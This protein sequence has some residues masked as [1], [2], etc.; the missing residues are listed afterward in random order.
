MS[1]IDNIKNAFKEVE[2]KVEHALDP[3]EEAST[4][5]VSTTVNASLATSVVTDTATVVSGDTH[6]V[7][8]ATEE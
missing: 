6:P 3:V 4:P 8:Q 5:T 2:S 7:I 1:I